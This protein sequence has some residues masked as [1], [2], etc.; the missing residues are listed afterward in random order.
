MDVKMRSKEDPD[1]AANKFP[2]EHIPE[3]LP[4]P[5]KDILQKVPPHKLLEA[6]KN[7]KKE[8]ET[9]SA[10]SDDFERIALLLD[11]AKHLINGTLPSPIEKGSEFYQLLE[12]IAK[13][14]GMVP[15]S[16]LQLSPEEFAKKHGVDLGKTVETTGWI[17]GE[18]KPRKK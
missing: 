6:V 12:E 9:E 15:G 13:Q 14:A 4:D 8:A 17:W 16:D 2:Y 7:R 10:G 3:G 18:P 11:L 1:M 5:V